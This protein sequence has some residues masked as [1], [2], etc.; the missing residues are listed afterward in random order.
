[1]WCAGHS[2]AVVYVCF[3][4]DGNRLLTISYDGSACLWDTATGKWQRRFKGTSEKPMWSAAFSPDEQRL[5]T[6]SGDASATV[7]SVDKG[8]PVTAPFLGHTKA[9]CTA[10]FS[11]DGKLIATGGEDKQVILWDPD[12]VEPYTRR[13]STAVDP[14]TVAVLSGHTA[15]VR[16]LR[17]SA[18]GTVLFSA[19]SDNTL[20]VWNVATGMLREDAAWPLERP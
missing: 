8:M 17:F 20:R 2:D 1:M 14:A 4:H 12:K 16:C 7:W 18:D 5:V 10:A 15:A 9:V 19:G 13:G 11:P 6:A 3:S